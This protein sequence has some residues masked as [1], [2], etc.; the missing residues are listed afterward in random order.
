L[1]IKKSNAENR[2]ATRLLGERYIERLCKIF[3]KSDV[4]RILFDR[5]GRLDDA[6]Y[7]DVGLGEIDIF[8]DVVDKVSDNGV[9][10][11]SVQ[12]TAKDNDY[13]NSVIRSSGFTAKYIGDKRQRGER[14]YTVMISE[15]VDS[16]D[17]Y[18][19]LL[20]LS[21]VFDLSVTFR[22]DDGRSGSVTPYAS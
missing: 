1:G 2:K 16:Y 3:G 11:L 13:L 14:I 12:M 15:G 9:L 21:E 7:Y 4:F 20:R 18:V 8:S 10:F 22:P 19:G 6:F 5:H 17:L